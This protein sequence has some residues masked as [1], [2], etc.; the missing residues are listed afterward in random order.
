MERIGIYGGTFNPPHI[1]HISAALQA[2][3]ALRLDRLLLIPDRIAPHKQL[4]EGS[5][6][7]EQ[8]LEMLEIAAKNYPQLE[9]SDME[10]LREGTSYTY[11][12]ILELKGII[13]RLPGK[14][15]ILN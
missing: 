11:L 2:V 12:T 5:A 14:R 7:P 13:R 9:V 10:L 4:P 15:I 3:D 6:T 8:R 1:G